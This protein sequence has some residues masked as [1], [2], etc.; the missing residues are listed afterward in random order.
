[1]FHVK[2]RLLQKKRHME[3][4]KA[5]TWEKTVMFHVKQ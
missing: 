2:H 5:A 3:N 4:R 1:M